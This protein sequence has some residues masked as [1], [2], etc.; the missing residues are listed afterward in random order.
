[1]LFE[2]GLL[3]ELECTAEKMWKGEVQAEITTSTESQSC[4]RE[5]C[6]QRVVRSPM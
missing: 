2:A 4:D 1:M 3:D 5:R 6:V